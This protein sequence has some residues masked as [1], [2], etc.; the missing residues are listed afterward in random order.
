MRYN[1][2]IIPPMAIEDIFWEHTNNPTPELIA[3]KDNLARNIQIAAAI[4]EELRAAMS[5]DTYPDPHFVEQVLLEKGLAQNGDQL[6]ALLPA[7]IDLLTA[8]GDELAA[9]VESMQA[10][11]PEATTELQSH[12][13]D[14]RRR[15]R[16]RLIGRALRPSLLR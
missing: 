5:L 1:S 6:Y 12:R 13:Q 10:T 2:Y 16:A 14:T 15:S 9:G 11:T 3:E 7:A 8:V 4:L